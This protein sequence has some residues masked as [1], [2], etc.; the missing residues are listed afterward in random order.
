MRN[1]IDHRGPV[2]RRGGRAWRALGAIALVA[3]LLS[4]G[5]SPMG[6]STVPV[7][8]F[9]PLASTSVFLMDMDGQKLHEW[10]TDNAPGYSVYLL[11]NGNLLRASSLDG[12]PFNALQGSNGGRVEML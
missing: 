1:D 8:L 4:C 10:P 6:G 5:G 12:R 3:A 7:I 9:S 2:G 11:P